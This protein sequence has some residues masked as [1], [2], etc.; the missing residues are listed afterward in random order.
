MRSVVELFQPLNPNYTYEVPCSVT[1]DGA[2]PRFGEISIDLPDNIKT[3]ELKQPIS[4]SIGLFV[5]K[6][7]VARE[8]DDDDKK[9]LKELLAQQLRKNLPMFQTTLG[10]FRRLH[11]EIKKYD[12]GDQDPII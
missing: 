10:P 1:A 7:E 12:E 9:Q 11:T 2:L 8:L 4:V 3:V 5:I 6:L